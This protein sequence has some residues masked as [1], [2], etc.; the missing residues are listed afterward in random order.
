MNIQPGRLKQKIQ[1]Y[2]LDINKNEN[3]FY[4]IIKTPLK[5]L[6]SETKIKKR[7]LQLEDDVLQAY[8]TIESYAY[9]REELLNSDL[10]LVV[11]FKE[12]EWQLLEIYDVDLEHK[13]LKLSAKTL[14]TKLEIYEQESNS[15]EPNGFNIKKI[16]ECFGEIRIPTDT[17][18]TVGKVKTKDAIQEFRIE[19]RNIND[20]FIP[21]NGQI[22]K[23]Q[24]PFLKEEYKIV[25]IAI[26]GSFITL[27]L[28]E[29]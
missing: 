20:K 23:V 3:G 21:K 19:I 15:P 11:D 12:K 24:H 6:Y 1:F 8:D 26:D 16:Y 4:E 29:V 13:F 17:S 28:A 18:K 5:N 7:N 9:Y 27:T 2:N 14:E 25:K 22:V 10:C